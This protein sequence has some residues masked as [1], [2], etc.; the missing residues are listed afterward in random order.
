MPATR[1]P[2]AAPTG[3][4]PPAAAHLPTP[5]PPARPAQVPGLSAGSCWN[6]KALTIKYPPLKENISADV[7]V[8]GAGIAGLSCAYNLA[9]E[10]GYAARAAD[11]AQCASAVL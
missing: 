5:S 1:P 4:C 3:C 7:V 9:K 8:V 6:Q 10:G 2:A 11:A